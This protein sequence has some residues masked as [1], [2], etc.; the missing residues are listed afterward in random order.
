MAVRP[1]QGL[2]VVILMNGWGERKALGAYALD[3]VAAA[4][5]GEPSRRRRTSRRTRT[6]RGATRIANAEGFT[7][8][9]TGEGRTWRLRPEDDGVFLEA[10][11]VGVRL[12]RLGEGLLIAPHPALERFPIRPIRGEDG[13]V[14]RARDTGRTATSARTRIV[15]SPRPR[16]P[17]GRRSRAPTGAPARGTRCYGSTRAA[18][19]CG[20]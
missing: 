14:R 4:L 1:G 11:P 9:F 10:G 7:G 5:A 19:S 13:A 12:E 17:D 18:A 20:S 16:L 6:S 8:S 15:R 2:G 3:A